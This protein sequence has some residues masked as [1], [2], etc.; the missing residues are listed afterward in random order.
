MLKYQRAITLLIKFHFSRVVPSST[1]GAFKTVLLGKPHYKPLAKKLLIRVPYFM[2]KSDR[3][4]QLDIQSLGAALQTYVRSENVFVKE[5]HIE[6]RFFRLQYPYLDSTIL[7]QYIAINAGKYNFNRMQKRLFRGVGSSPLSMPVGS[8]L[9]T[10][11]DQSLLSLSDRNSEP[12]FDKLLTNSLVTGHGSQVTGHGRGSAETLRLR[13]F[14]EHQ[15]Q[16][17]DKEGVPQAFYANTAALSPYN[18][19]GVKMELAGRLTTQRNIPRKTVSNAHTGSFTYNKRDSYLDT[20]LY[21]SKNK[22]GSFTIKV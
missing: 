22:I 6:L 16:G 7:S 5:G 13:G 8:L 12:T 17:A 1:K 18:V 9:A 2:N 11:L 14:I 20:G 3:L 15:P 10:T 19:T 4:K 21:A